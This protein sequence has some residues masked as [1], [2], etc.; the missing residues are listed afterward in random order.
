MKML[1]THLRYSKGMIFDDEPV[2]NTSSDTIDFLAASELF[3]GLLQYSA[4]R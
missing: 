1:L 3:S 4:L 2:S